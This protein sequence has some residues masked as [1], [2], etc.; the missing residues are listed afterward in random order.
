MPPKLGILAGRGVL[1]GRLAQACL[2][3]GRDYFVLAFN[4]ETDPVAIEGHP[5][6]WVD[7]PA[8]GR[9]IAAL[10]QAGAQELVL[11]G[12]VGRPDF[13]NLKPDWRGARLLPKIIRAARL[14]DDAI[15]KVLVEELEAEGF[16]VVGAEAVLNDLAAPGGL[17]AGPQPQ[18]REWAD[19]RRGIEVLRELGRLDIGQA[20]VVREGYVLAVEAAEGTDAMLRRCRGFAGDGLGGVLVKL[21]K[22]DQ[23]RRADLPTIGV[24]TVQLC[25]EARLAGIAIEAGGALVTDAE[26]VIATAS[27]AGLFVYGLNPDELEHNGE[28]RG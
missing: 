8:I 19:I 27:D 2:A 1:P 11:I 10:K 23:E 18:W 22:P 13:R 16:K 17:I 6:A 4:G 26:A 9:G 20:V 14:G 24:T 25:A 15:M 28:G 7:L 21:P 12:P 5:Q 3:N